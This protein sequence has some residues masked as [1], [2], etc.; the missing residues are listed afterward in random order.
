MF[1]L[2]DAQSPGFLT[3][4]QGLSLNPPPSKTKS[5]KNST[6]LNEIRQNTNSP[7]K[8]FYSD[9]LFRVCEPGVCWEGQEAMAL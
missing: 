6:Q 2:T 8:E 9:P 3:F 1:L 7:L 5:C 4:V